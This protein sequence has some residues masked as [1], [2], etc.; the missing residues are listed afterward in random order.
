MTI[1]KIKGT[2]PIFFFTSFLHLQKLLKVKCNYV[3][4]MRLVFLVFIVV[5]MTE[6]LLDSMYEQ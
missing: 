4:T 6:T 1:S 3:T 5:G 2:Q